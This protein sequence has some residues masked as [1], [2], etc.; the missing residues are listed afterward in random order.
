[1]KST[2]MDPARRRFLTQFVCGS[3]LLGLR[4]LATGLPMQLLAN[5]RPACALAV[6][7]TFKNPQYLI[8]NTSQA[9]DPLNCNAPGTYLDAKIA[10]P[11]D[12][13]LQKT[14]LM[15][16]GASYDA[17][18]PWATLGSFERTTFIHHSTQTEQHLAEPEVLGLMGT[19]VDKDMAVSAFARILAPVLGTIQLQPVSIGTTDSSEA[20]SYQGRPQPLLNPTALSVLL[21][22][23][24]GMLG[25]LQ[26]LRDRDLNRLNAL[27]KAQGN[28]EQRRFLDDYATSQTQVRQLSSDLLTR[29]GAITN[30]GP[31]GQIQAA[32]V[33]VQLK[34]APVITVHIPF[35]G[36]NHFD[37]DLTQEADQTVSGMNT[38]AGL[39]KGLSE[40][41]LSD[42]V[43]FASLNVFGRTLLKHGSGRSHNRNHHLTLIIGKNVKG[44]VIGGVTPMGDDYAA[45]PISSTTGAGAASGDIAA[46]DALP[47][48]G[49]T[50]GAA[51]GLPVSELDKTVVVPSSGEP[52]GKVIQAALSV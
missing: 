45:L 14:A 44:S 29:L 16:G 43:T 31:D 30:N 41:K 25:Q 47:S 38:I 7:A 26:K 4:A 52:A 1:M 2:D 34:V 46:A 32:L 18:A 48:V 37:G 8:L 40:Q 28:R 21:G 20:I 22:A 23:P 11:A 35:G 19:V 39:L 10:H 49:R 36:D 6:T 24:D 42:H 27:F 50:L 17:A 3:G 15:I 13:R 51:L 12:P 5:P 9:G 33:L